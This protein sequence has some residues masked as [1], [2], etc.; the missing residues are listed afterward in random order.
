MHVIAYREDQH[1]KEE[2]DKKDSICF[3]YICLDEGIPLN[4]IIDGNK[5]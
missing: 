3:I 2:G 1:Y 4:W 5:Q